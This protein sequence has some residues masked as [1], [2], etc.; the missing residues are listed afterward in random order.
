MRADK[1]AW[2]EEQCGLIDEFDKKHKSKELF[3]QIKTVKNKK[4]SSSQLP[5]KNKD[6]VTVTEKADIMA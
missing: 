6:N 2:L 3:R 1:R 4:S 5:I